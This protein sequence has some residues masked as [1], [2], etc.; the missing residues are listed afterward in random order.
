MSKALTADLVLQRTKASS[1]D[2]VKN[3][4]LW[5]NDIEDVRILK[6]MPNLEVL[7]LSVN[8]ISTLK[9]F[10]YCKKL[11]EL[12]LRKNLIADLSELRY[13]QQ[14]PYLKVLW[15]WD[16]PC[17]EV[18]NYREIVISN[19]PNLVKLDNQAIS[20]EEKAQAVAK[21]PQPQR[22][23]REER[24]EPE[25]IPKEEPPRRER[26]PS[27]AIKEP[28]RSRPRRENDTRTDNILCAILALLKEL[29][30]NSLEI[31]RREIEKKLQ[32]LAIGK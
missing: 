8:K 30:E 15:L 2:T 1:L 7:S 27:P 28:P 18:P 29:D 10:Q 17:A 5:G 9:P 13:I 25:Y 4:N 6:D 24:K 26:D 3:L 21:T 14:L 11:T 31:V 32:S 20:P 12:Y 19:M 22:V 16:N 23:R